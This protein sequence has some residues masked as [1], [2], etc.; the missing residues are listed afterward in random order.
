[1]AAME[2]KIGSTLAGVLL[3]I[4]KKPTAQKVINTALDGTTYIQNTGYPIMRYDVDCYCATPE[5]RELV[6]DACND[7]SIITLTDRSG[8]EI[9]G[10]I[11]ENAVKWKEW[12]DGHGVGKFTLIRR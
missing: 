12:I 4:T 10:Y 7:G 3:N 6:D 1:M 9:L 8:T 11:E 5:N 2:L